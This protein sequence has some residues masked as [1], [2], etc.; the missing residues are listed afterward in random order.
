MGTLLVIPTDIAVLFPLIGLVTLLIHDLS[1]IHIWEV[2]AS[3]ASR[4]KEF[5]FTISA[6]F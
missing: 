5:Y 2:D 1:L 4:R 6:N 3:A